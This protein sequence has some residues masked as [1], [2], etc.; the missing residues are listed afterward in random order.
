MKALSRLTITLLCIS[1]LLPAAAMLSWQ[2]LV[3]D[4]QEF[5]NQKLADAPVPGIITIP[6]GSFLMGDTTGG[7]PA[8]AQPPHKVTFAAPFGMSATEVTV[9]EFAFFVEHS[10]YGVEPGCW[11]HD[12]D[13]EWRFY[14]ELT[15]QN[16]GYQQSKNHP[17]TCVSIADARAYALWLSRATGDRYRLPSEAELEYAMRIGQDSSANP[18]VH[19]QSQL[20]RFMNGADVSS[21]WEYGNQHCDDGFQ[22]TSP[23]ASYLPNH[24]GLYDISGN[25]WEWAEDC[26]NDTYKTRFFG[27]RRAPE[28]GRAWTGGDCDHH[29][30]R[31]GSW[32]SSVVRLSPSYRQR[33]FGEYRLNSNGF[34]LVKDFN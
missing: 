25:L 31:G 2:T 29:A 8:E 33:N 12:A 3:S 17:V 34:R 27:L 26:W 19:D 11:N 20:C 23:V 16:P 32:L 13:Q 15:W 14:P 7:G 30:T 10:G 9:G 4:R 1:L 28:D 6:A 24:L 5:S 22:F 21:G 18:T